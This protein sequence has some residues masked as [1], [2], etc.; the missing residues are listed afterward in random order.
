[1]V[2]RVLIYGQEDLGS[3]QRERERERERE[4]NRAWRK[5]VIFLESII[6]RKV[7]QILLK[8]F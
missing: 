8:Y 6:I 1:L 2:G 4:R 3:N 7:H 5:F